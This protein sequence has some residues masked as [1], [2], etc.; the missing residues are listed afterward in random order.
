MVKSESGMIGFLGTS[1]GLSFNHTNAFFYRNHHDGKDIFFIDLSALNYEKAAKLASDDSVNDIYLMLTHMHA[2]HSSGAAFI[3]A[4]TYFEEHKLL[5]FIIPIDMLHDFSEMMDIYGT[6]DEKY[7]IWTIERDNS[8]SP[9]DALVSEDEMKIAERL[10]LIKD[11]VKMA[12]PVKHDEYLRTPCFGYRIHTDGGFFVYSGDTAE[13]EPVIAELR[14]GDALY[15]EMRTKTRASSHLI[16][17]KNE[18]VIRKISETHPVWLM[19][20]TNEALLRAYTE[21]IPNVA[22]AKPVDI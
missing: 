8:I 12:F 9:P 19:H 10:S 15:C 3:S 11:T 18:H 5:N 7:Y 6:R 4:Y 17:I 20:Y 1:Y 16:W 21:N 13:I 14:E 2:D 22:V